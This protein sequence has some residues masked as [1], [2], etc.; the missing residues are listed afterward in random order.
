MSVIGH[1]G[2]SGIVT[3]VTHFDLKVRPVYATVLLA[4]WW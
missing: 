4:P 1:P 2:L 3:H